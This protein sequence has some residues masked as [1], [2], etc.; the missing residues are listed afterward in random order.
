MHYFPLLTELDSSSLKRDQIYSEET[1]RHESLK[2]VQHASDLAKVGA[3]KDQLN[4]SSLII[5]Y[6][7]G[8]VFKIN[9]IERLARRHEI[10]TLKA[11]WLFHTRSHPW[12]EFLSNVKGNSL[13]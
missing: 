6:K 4:I 8:L 2:G 3:C 1:N 7:C 10:S 12:C 11:C 5:C 13:F 9:E